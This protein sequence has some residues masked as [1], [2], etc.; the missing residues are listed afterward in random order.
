M[1]P[2]V[3]G[4]ASQAVDAYV[5]DYQWFLQGLFQMLVSF[6]LLLLVLAAA[7]LL[8]AAFQGQ[9]GVFPAPSKYFRK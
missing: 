3:V 6:W 2:S 4:A 1:L 5:F 9:V 8:R 7:I